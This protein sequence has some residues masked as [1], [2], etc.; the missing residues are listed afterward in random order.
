MLVNSSSISLS[1]L[2][3]TEINQ[4]STNANNCGPSPRMQTVPSLRRRVCSPSFL[5][6]ARLAPGRSP[7]EWLCHSARVQGRRR[8]RQAGAKAPIL[9]PFNTQEGT[10]LFLLGGVPVSLR[11]PDHL[12]PLPPMLHL[13]FPPEALMPTGTDLDDDRR[14]AS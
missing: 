8:R 3:D 12:E 14:Q 7:A 9:V 4:C 5:T 10:S 2:T 1:A 13:P 6:V 11:L